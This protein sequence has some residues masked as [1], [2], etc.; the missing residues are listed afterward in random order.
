M[1]TNITVLTQEKRWKGD[2]LAVK[3][4]AGAAISAEKARN[5]NVTLVLANDRKVKKL[6]HMYRGKN[7]PTNV[8]SFPDGSKER[9]L[10]HLGDI[11][12]AYETI[13]R[14]A[15]AQQKDF[16]QHAMHL[17]VHG[18]LHLLGYDHEK[19]KEAE[20]MEAKEI[21]ILAG[22]RIANPYV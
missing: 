8:L 18:V 6:N 16:R 7:K 17:A 1:A 19:S 14:E 21:K 22:L 2:Q 4:A 10:T 15:K 12:L 13:A 11:V 5:V 3:R 20:T 9:K